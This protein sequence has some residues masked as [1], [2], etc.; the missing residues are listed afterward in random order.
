[1]SSRDSGKTPLEAVLGEIIVT[2]EKLRWLIAE[3]EEALKPERRSAGVMVGRVGASGM[4]VAG[5]WLGR[6]R[7]AATDGGGA[8]WTVPRALN[9]LHARQAVPRP[10]NAPTQLRQT[11]SN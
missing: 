3:G 5:G 4:E 1:M 2:A 8:P 10:C 6:R 7:G 11:S 9:T